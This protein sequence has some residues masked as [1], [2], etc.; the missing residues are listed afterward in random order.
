[1]VS[2]IGG[3]SGLSVLASYAGKRLVAAKQNVAAARPSAPAARTAATVNAMVSRL[4]ALRDTLTRADFSPQQATLDEIR[5]DRDVVDIRP[6]YRTE[7]IVEREDVFETEQVVES[8]RVLNQREIREQQ[9]LMRTRD[10]VE[11]RDVFEEQPVYEDQ[12]V[13]GPASVTGTRNLS[14]FSSIS[15]AGIDTGADFSVQVGSGPVARVRFQSSTRIRVTIDGDSTNFNFQT[16]NGSWRTALVDALNS[17]DG[18]TASLSS[19]RLTIATDAGETLTIAHV[20]NGSDNP[21]PDIGLSAG[22]TLP[23]VTGTQQVQVGTLQVKVGTEDVVVGTE[24]FVARTKQAVIATEAVVIGTEGTIVGTRSTAIGSRETIVGTRQVFERMEQAVVGTENVLV[25][26]SRAA[27][28][29]AASREPLA[30]RID[31]ARDLIDIGE[32]ATSADRDTAVAKIDAELA[33]L[34]AAPDDGPG[35]PGLSAAILLAA[36]VAEAT[37]R[38]PMAR[39]YEGPR[40]R[41][42]ILLRL[43]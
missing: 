26:Y 4:R 31:A 19:G 38:Q 29:R 28:A 9:N 30:E 1:M 11:T 33:R 16:N 43:A 42:S 17:I 2:G 23:A 27:P 25:G 39:I 6:V 3:V 13:Y 36:Q 40:P 22:T 8:R 35:G 7:T 24:Q 34:G 18:V 5:Q 21:L 14:S 41:A 15:S 12:P 20:P 10:V 32:V 37:P